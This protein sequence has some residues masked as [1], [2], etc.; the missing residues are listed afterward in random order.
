MRVPRDD[1]RGAPRVET[2]MAYQLPLA[3][4]PP[5]EPP[6]PPPNPPPPPPKPPPPNPPPPQPPR[7]I[8]LAINGPIHQPLPPP[9]PRPEPPPRLI[10]A[11]T[12]KMKTPRRIRP[13]MPLASFPRPEPFVW[14]VGGGAPLSAIPRSCAM[15]SAMRRVSNVTAA[16]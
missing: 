2:F 8:P 14:G 7:P 11:Y 15:T 3:P 10:I 16:S 4:P 6:P 5:N 1:T 9:R 13:N 12:K